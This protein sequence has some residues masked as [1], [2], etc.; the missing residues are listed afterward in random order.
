MGAR[1]RRRLRLLVCAMLALATFATIVPACRPSKPPL[2]DASGVADLPQFVGRPEGELRAALSQQL[3]VPTDA[4][5]KALGLELHVRDG[6]VDTLFVTLSQPDGQGPIYRGPLFRGVTRAMHRRDVE[7]LLGPPDRTADPT[8]I[9]MFPYTSMEWIKYL[10]PEAQI[11]FQFAVGDG[12]IEMITLMRPD[13][14][15]G[16]P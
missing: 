11:H 9:P 4:D 15:P 14:E 5:L 12:P 6:R 7:A 16:D 1:E 8:A 13:W 10:R 3:G 2:I